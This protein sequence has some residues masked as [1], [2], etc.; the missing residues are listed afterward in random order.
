[1]T[2]LLLHKTDLG[3]DDLFRVS[4]P[5]NLNRLSTLY[6]LVDR[7]DLKFPGFEPCVPPRLKQTEDLF[8]VLRRGD[9]LL[10]HPYESFGPVLEFLRQAAADKDVLAIKQTLYRTGPESPMVAALIDAA[11][12]GKDVTAVVE[13][14]ARF[15]EAANIDLATRLQQAGANIVYGIVGY[16]THAK[17]LLVVRREAKRLRRYVHLGTGNYHSLTARVYS[18]LGLLTADRNVGE[19]VHALFQELTGLGRA[20]KLKRLLQSPFTLHH[21]LI[22]LIDAEADE[23]RAGR[24][25]RIVARM[26]GLSE[27]EI[28][29][30]LYRASQAGVSIDLIVRG[31][32]ALKPGVPGV[33]EHIRVRSL[34]G[35]FLE[36]ARAFRFHAAGEDLVFLS[37]A[38]WMERNLFRRVETCVPVLDPRLKQRVID[39]GLAPFL[40]DNT[41]AWLLQ[42]D[43]SYERAVPRDGDPVFSAQA[44]LLARLAR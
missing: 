2:Q 16:K 38:D 34:V 20:P 3:P 28:I 30:A 35:R 4:G 8:A 21:R 43:G 37:S 29:R 33:S 24:P 17:M 7:P 14:R 9:V 36:H 31:I 23:A 42:T 12:A 40:A 11:R 32:C 27:P 41:Q 1:M 39:E 10:H 6:G 22:A 18:D 25:A 19:D 5:V 26:N 13:L 44:D 15:D